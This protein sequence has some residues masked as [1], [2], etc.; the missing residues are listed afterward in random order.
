M[1]NKKKGMK[2]GKVSQKNWIFLKSLEKWWMGRTQEQN[3]DFWLI[4]LIFINTNSKNAKRQSSLF[5]FIIIFLFCSLCLVNV[6]LWCFFFSKL[7]Q[8]S[9]DWEQSLS[10]LSILISYSNSKHITALASCH[11][12]CHSFKT[13]SK[14][15]C[16]L[17]TV[18]C[19]PFY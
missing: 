8:T 15:I 2:I 5:F 7:A 4:S 17:Q 14:S 3:Q 10:N 13:P 11:R 6:Y 18:S 9:E 12:R 1:L 19:W 16:S